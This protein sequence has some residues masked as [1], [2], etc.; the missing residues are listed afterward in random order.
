MVII[1]RKAQ[2]PYQ[3]VIAIFL[4]LTASLNTKKLTSYQA[5]MRIQDITI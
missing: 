1:F 2:F 3:H 4:L 5:R